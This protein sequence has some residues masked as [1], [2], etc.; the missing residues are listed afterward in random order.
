MT[1]IKLISFLVVN[2]PSEFV[3]YRANKRRERRCGNP[4]CMSEDVERIHR[5]KQ[6]AYNLYKTSTSSKC[7]KCGWRRVD[8]PERRKEFSWIDLFWRFLV[9]KEQFE[10]ENDGSMSPYFV[11]SDGDMSRR[12][13]KAVPM[14]E[15]FK[16]RGHKSQPH[17]KPPLPTPLIPGESKF[18]RL[19]SISHHFRS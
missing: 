8:K 13:L 1:V 16:S 14:R 7:R 2:E 10:T 3:K 6:V 17:P 19:I 5:M 9:Y 12:V 18:P 11:Y 15:Y 4:D